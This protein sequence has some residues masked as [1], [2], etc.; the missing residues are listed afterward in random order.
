MCQAQRWLRNDRRLRRCTCSH[1][2]A[3][4]QARWVKKRCPQQRFASVRQRVA[5]RPTR[6]ALSRLPRLHVQ[7]GRCFLH[8]DSCSTQVLS[9]APLW[10]D[11][12]SCKANPSQVQKRASQAYGRGGVAGRPPRC[13]LLDSEDCRILVPTPNQADMAW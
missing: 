10:A 4:L 6:A 5:S 1:T 12:K 2:Q 11:R 9:Q 8:L 3:R 7:R 13:H